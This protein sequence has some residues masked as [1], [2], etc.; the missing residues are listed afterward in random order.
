MTSHCEIEQK[1]TLPIELKQE[2]IDFSMQLLES[3]PVRYHL[4]DY[5]HNYTK[6]DNGT[7]DFDRLRIMTNTATG[8]K[9]YLWTRKFTETDGSHREDETTITVHD[10]AKRV[11][12][13]TGKILVKERFDWHGD[14]LSDE[15]NIKGLAIAVDT[16][17]YLPD[18]C[19][20]ELEVLRPD[21][22]DKK[23]IFREFSHLIDLSHLPATLTDFSMSKASLP[24]ECNSI[25]DIY[26]FASKYRI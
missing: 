18:E 2:A 22:S 14:L 16:V 19:Y 6:Y 23:A 15:L 1:Y 25:D 13:T 12:N 4:I 21:E 10:A 7:K 11:A 20:W 9:I 8:E 26:A 24:F 5:R 3:E 17:P